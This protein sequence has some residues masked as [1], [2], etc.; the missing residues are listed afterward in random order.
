MFRGVQ[1]ATDTSALRCDRS[2]LPRCAN[3][4][5]AA[6]QVARRR[7]AAYLAGPRG[8]TRLVVLAGEV[9]GRWSVCKVQG[10]AFAASFLEL[11]GGS[12]ADGD[13]HPSHEVESTFKHA[14]L[15]SS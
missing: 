4:D 3:V 15:G 13:T 11:L 6:F 2:A 14:R 7:K 9:A 12:S 5:G 8:R 1:L 10:K